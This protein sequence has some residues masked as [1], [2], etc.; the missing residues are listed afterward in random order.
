MNK[1]FAKFMALAVS[2]AMII[3]SVA[4]ANG[5]SVEDLIASYE[6]Y[7]RGESE[8]ENPLEV[9]ESWTEVP[10]G[11]DPFSDME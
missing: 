3:P 2:A 5:K 7:A 9:F 11:E 10:F 4:I 8:A 1:I 6:E